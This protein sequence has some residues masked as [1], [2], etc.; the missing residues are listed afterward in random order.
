[1][2]TELYAPCVFVMATTRNIFHKWCEWNG[3]L[4]FEALYINDS[5]KPLRGLSPHVPLIILIGDDLGSFSFTQQ[6]LVTWE[7]A[8]Q[9]LGM[10]TIFKTVTTPLYASEFFARRAY[11]TII[12]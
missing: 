11:S 1:M 5:Y 9:H 7:L 6:Q 2:R 3:L 10:K 4:P 8:E 12:K